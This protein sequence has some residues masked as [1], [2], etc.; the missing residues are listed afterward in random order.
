MTEFE[1]TKW[2]D[3]NYWL[4]GELKCDRDKKSL[5]K[6]DDEMQKKHESEN[7]INIEFKNRK[8]V[9]EK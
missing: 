4:F 3:R 2:S 5:Y 6:F 7:A 8:N 1:I 9:S